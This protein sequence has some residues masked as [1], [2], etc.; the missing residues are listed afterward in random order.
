MAALT[1]L[2]R[3]IT[4]HK[5]LFQALITQREQDM[6]SPHPPRAY[7][8]KAKADAKPVTMRVTAV[9]QPAFLIDSLEEEMTNSCSLAHPM[10]QSRLQMVMQPLLESSSPESFLFQ[11]QHVPV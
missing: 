7:S 9:S 10:Q 1:A 6:C 2:H 4:E 8:L 11:Q 3:A 5:A